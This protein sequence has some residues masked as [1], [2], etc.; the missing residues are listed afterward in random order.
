MQVPDVLT[1]GNHMEIKHWRENEKLKRTKSRRK[2]LIQ[3]NNFDN[4]DSSN[5]EENGFG[6]LAN[7]T[8]ALWKL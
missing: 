6:I 8:K 4:K 5:S 3:N 2:D 7:F 1:S